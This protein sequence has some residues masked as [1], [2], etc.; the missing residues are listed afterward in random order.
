MEY[1]KQITDAY[2]NSTSGMSTEDLMNSLESL[3]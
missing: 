1:S 3:Q 2:T